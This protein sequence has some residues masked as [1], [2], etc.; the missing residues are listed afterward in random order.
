[1]AERVLPGVS[2]EVKSEGLITTTAG[3]PNVIGLIGTAN[4]GPIDVVT[5]VGSFSEA[6]EIF[7]TDD[8][9]LTIKKAL[10]LAYGEGATTVRCVRIGDGTEAYATK[11]LLNGATP[12]ITLNGLYKGTYGNQISVTVTANATTPA[13]RDLT[14][15]DGSLVETYI[16]KATNTEIIEKINEVS[17]LCSA[18]LTSATPLVDITSITNLAGGDDGESVTNGDYVSGL[19]LFESEDI[20]IVVCAGQS[21]DA[22]HASMNSHCQNMAEVGRERIAIGGSALGESITTIKARTTKSDRF[23]FVCP[24]V[25]V[26]DAQ[27]GATVTRNGAYSASGVAGMLAKYDVQT[28]LTNKQVTSAVDVEDAYTDA[29]LKDLLNDERCPLRKKETIRVARGITSSTNSAWKQITTRRI[30]DYVS[31][32]VRT[33]GDSFI[34]RLNNTRVRSALKG[35][36]D[37]FLNDLTNNEVLIA[38]NAEVSATRSDEIAGVCKVNLQIQPVFSIDFIEVVIYLQ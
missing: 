28:S 9:A 27:T 26:I 1:M 16:N 7:G 3:A 10:E 35:V 14:I 33:A 34:G 15:T 21:D 6:V 25:E 37:S 22:L 17:S 8:T 30:V 23:V 31:D 19:S 12:V 11:V 36:V 5:T 18:V 38:F 13:N 4:W 20:N 2:V 32:G 24:G 29:N